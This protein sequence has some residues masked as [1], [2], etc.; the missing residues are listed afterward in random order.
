MKKLSDEDW[1]RIKE[2]KEDLTNLEIELARK[3]NVDYCKMVINVSTG[4]IY[5]VG[6]HE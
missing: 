3:Y 5:E 6:N 4:Y 2:Q 1:Q